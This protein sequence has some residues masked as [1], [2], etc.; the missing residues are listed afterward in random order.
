V[1]DQLVENSKWPEAEDD[2]FLFNITTNS[3]THAL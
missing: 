1:S 2:S 3:I